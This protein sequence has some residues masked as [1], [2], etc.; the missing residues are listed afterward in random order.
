MNYFC[1]FLSNA[2]ESRSDHIHS[3]YGGMT[4]VHHSTIECTE[5]AF[6]ESERCTNDEPCDTTKCA[7]VAHSNIVESVETVEGVNLAQLD[8]VEGV[9]DVHRGIETCRN[10]VNSTDNGQEIV[11]M[12]VTD[13]SEYPI[14][15]V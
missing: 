12:K 4:P 7:D 15:C 3:I 8:T 6:S 9:D 14:Q 5:D 2:A 10:F 11:S 1:H 13:N